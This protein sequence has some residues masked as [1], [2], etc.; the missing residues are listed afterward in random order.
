MA[1][2]LLLAMLHGGAAHGGLGQTLTA[3]RKQGRCWCL[4][5]CLDARATPALICCWQEAAAVAAGAPPAGVSIRPVGTV[6]V[7]THCS[8]SCQPFRI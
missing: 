3:Q 7:H 1:G 6:A 4:L 5:R 2:I 8:W